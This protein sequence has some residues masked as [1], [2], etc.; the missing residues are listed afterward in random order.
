MLQTKGD[1]VFKSL[2]HRSKEEGLL[3]VKGRFGINFINDE[4]RIKTP[5]V[6]RK[7]SSIE[8]TLEEAL[9]LTAKNLQLVRGQYGSDSVAIL[10]ITKI[11]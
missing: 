10:S 5:I 2:P 4:S 8:V 3:C 9:T 1:L 11:Y 6:R 7:D